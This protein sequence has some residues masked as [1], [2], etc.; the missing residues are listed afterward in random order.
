MPSTARSR[1]RATA[2]SCRPASTCAPL[3]D[4][5]LVG[6]DHVLLAVRQVLHPHVRAQQV[7]RLGIRDPLAVGRELRARDIAGTRSTPAPRPCRSRSPRA[8]AC[9]PSRSTAATSNPAP[10]RWP[11]LSQSASLSFFV[12][13]AELVGDLDLLAAGA[14]GDEGDPLAVGRPARALLRH[15]VSVTRCG[16]PRSVAMVKIS[17]CTATAARCSRARGGS[18]PPRC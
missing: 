16:S 12:L 18:P 4:Q 11:I 17:P 13:L 2:V 1:R 6:G 10:R 9:D 8:A 3:D 5:E 7:V 14:V 15:G